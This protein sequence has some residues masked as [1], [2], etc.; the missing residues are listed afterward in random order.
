MKQEENRWNLKETEKLELT[1]QIIAEQTF[2]K[3][4]EALSLRK[5]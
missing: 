5:S 1:S 2:K 3:R 4:E